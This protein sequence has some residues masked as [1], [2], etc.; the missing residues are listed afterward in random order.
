MGNGNKKLRGL[1]G[2][3]IKYDM[4]MYIYIQV[5]IAVRYF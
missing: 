2:S 5:E 1:G 3:I 4:Y